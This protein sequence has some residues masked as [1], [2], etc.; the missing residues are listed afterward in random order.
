MASKKS[1]SCLFILLFFI[2]FCQITVA[3]TLLDQFAAPDMWFNIAELEAKGKSIIPKKKGYGII[4]NSSKGKCKNIWTKKKYK[5]LEFHMEFMLAKNS[6]SGVYFM[7]RYE[8]QIL[9][10]YGKDKW[11][12]S[13]L[14]GLYQRWPPKSGP[15]VKPKVN[16]AKKPGEWQSMDVVFRAPRFGKD[17][18][19]LSQAMFKEVRINGQLVHENLYAVGPTRSSRFNNE[20]PV[21][22]IMIQ[23]DHGPIAVRNMTVKEIDLSKLPTKKLS[24]VES[25]PLNHQGKPMVELVSMGKDA[26]QNRGCMECHNTSI[27]DDIVKTGPSLY[28]IFQKSPKSIQVLESAEEHLV[29]IKA[30]KDY[31][32]RSIRDPLLHL[33]LNKKDQNKPFLPIMPAFLPD[34]VSDAEVEAIYAY[35]LTLNQP[36]Q[37][38]PMVTWV[39]QL[40]K[41]YT[42][43]EDPGA[44]IVQNRARL[45]RADLGTDTS[46]RSYHVGL[47]GDVNYSFDP[48]I[49]GIVK[50][51]NGPFVSIANMMD[52]RGRGDNQMGHDSIPW[53]TKNIPY[54]S[55][56]LSNGKTVDTNFKDPRAN[57]SFSVTEALKSTD[58]YVAKVKNLKS[59]FKGVKTNKHN[60]PKFF[61]EV[62]GNKIEVLFEAT[63]QNQISATLN[64]DLKTE[65]SFSFP[66]AAYQNIVVSHGKIEGNKWILPAGKNSKATLKADRK[67][68][69]RKVHIAGLQKI[70][71]E[72]LEPQSLIWKEANAKEQQ[73]AGIPQGYKLHT[74]V[75]PKDSYG[76]T[77]LFE[78]LGIAFLDKDTAF[79]STRT[80]GV[81]KI[82]H[83]KWHLFA[84][85]AYDALGLVIESENSIVIG[86]K[87]GLTRLI[88][89]NGDHWAEI[90]ENLSDHFRFH[91]NYHEYLHG[92]I[93]Y[94]GGYLYN[95]NLS[96]GLPANYQAGGRFMGTGGGLRGWMCHIDSNGQFSTFA[97]GFRSPAGLSLSPEGKVVYTENQGEYVGTSKVFTVN[98]GKFYGNPTG[99][100][101]LPG[102]TPKSPSIQWDAIK[103]KRETC[104]V[105]LP[106]REVMNAPGHPVWDLT[107]GEF[108][109]FA[110]Q[111]FLGDQTQSCIYRIDTQKINGIE[112]GVAI[113]FINKLASGI[114]RLTFNPKDNSLWVGQT[115]RGWASRGGSQAALQKISFTGQ[116]QELNMIKTVKATSKG[117]QVI[118]TKAQDTD[119]FGPITSQSWYYTDL[120]N[121]GSGEH[122]KRKEVFQNITWSEDRKTCYLDL[123]NFSVES[124][125]NNTNTSRVYRLDFKDTTFGKKVGPF[126]ARA[127]YTLHQIPKEVAVK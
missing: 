81:W 63:P 46:A 78:P 98:K 58:D 104:T 30:N 37:A 16:A 102:K 43:M 94:Q 114:M 15:G 14:G 2:A 42:L 118:F 21:G 5:D 73:A 29:N 123:Q 68:A 96:H 22:P 86:E 115:G 69:F 99:L 33:S 87:P 92:P 11:S 31:L 45:Q 124:K 107:Q 121:Y 64:V 72:N 48:S 50:V 6:N 52:G 105:L 8:I 71:Q 126:M 100:V 97:N 60:S 84:E 19:K 13:D 34:I 25:R 23:G 85:G 28:G 20:A 125:E 112:Q 108:G 90:Q 109:P 18:R 67:Q 47:P 106:H 17:G 12:F 40:N 26:F 44:V 70:P 101:D 76:R 55:P 27:K 91:G 49:L 127:Y 51:W 116:G 32:I 74:A 88:D 111:M 57:S 120:P 65:Q 79:V 110:G 59:K 3:E 62:D 24:E 41:Q 117:F 122:G 113:P 53:D 10:S 83:G 103:H 7:G 89:A 119:S 77:Q 1:T 80:A 93:P 54:L 36:E 35:L 82:K 66:S 75:L 38:G 4:L 61:Y 56:Y 95:L 9:D 39:N